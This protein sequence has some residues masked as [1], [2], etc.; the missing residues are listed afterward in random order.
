MLLLPYTQ[1]HTS[2]KEGNLYLSCYA[3]GHSRQR[4]CLA[5]D[6]LTVAVG[7]GHVT[8]SWPIGFSFLRGQRLPIRGDYPRLDTPQNHAEPASQPQQCIERE[9]PE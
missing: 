1:P 8:K 2:F 9:V 7:T 6:D 5:P 4:V 3:V